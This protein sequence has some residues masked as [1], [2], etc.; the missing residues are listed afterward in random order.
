VNDTQRRLVEVFDR[1]IGWCGALGSPLYVQLL[2]V[3][4]DDIARGGVVHDIVRGTADD[5][6]AAAVSLRLM[7]GVH[8]LVLMGL[9]EQLA[10]HYPSVGG[11]P[12]PATAGED[13]MDVVAAHP[14]YLRDALRI[15]PQTNDVGRSAL[16]L[17]GLARALDGRRLKVRLLGLGSA[18][19]LNLL[20]DR[21]RYD[22]D[23]TPWGD[24]GSPVR[25]A[26]TSKG[27]MPKLPGSLR[28][29]E[30]RGCDVNPMDITD[31]EAQLRLLSF[32]WPDQAERFARTRGA[33]SVAQIDPPIVDRADAAEWL[34]ARLDEPTPPNVM[35]VV[36]HS[37]MWQYLPATTRDELRSVIGAAG[38][39]ATRR[40][41]FAHV[42]FEPSRAP[43]ERGG[44]DLT[45][46][47]WPHGVPVVIADAHAH[48]R[49]IDWT[50]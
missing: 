43:T 2:T 40:R 17:A 22:F 18:G 5:P 45:V 30:R 25:I 37:V 29:V 8:R 12:D 26:T 46:T 20:L 35:T 47:V 11:T 39:R 19:G 24:P 15:A 31:P 23:G 7:G 1:Q 13:F 6:L 33:I 41:P 10:V 27:S 28:I 48:G 44:L 4:R 42:A 49:W 9:A 14:G 50:G 21:Y 32:I 16:L 34:A 38:A 3:A 36:Q